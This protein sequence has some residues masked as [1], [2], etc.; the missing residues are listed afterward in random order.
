MGTTVTT[1]GRPVVGES[2]SLTWLSNWIRVTSKQQRTS[3][4]ARRRVGSLRV[5]LP[6]RQDRG[7]QRRPAN[8][9]GAPRPRLEELPA[10]GQRVVASGGELFGDERGP[11]ASIL[12]ARARLAQGQTSR[13]S[14]CCS[15]R[16]PRP[17]STSE[18]R[19]TAYSVRVRERA[20]I[21]GR[22]DRLRAAAAAA[23]YPFLRAQFLS[24]A[25]RRGSRRVTRPRRWRPTARSRKSWTRQ[26]QRERRRCA[27]GS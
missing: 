3:R 22:R 1:A 7:A 6:D 27:S 24:D 26:A 15:V 17:T 18:P 8:R 5:E 19:A 2:K 21:S 13:R 10:R 14:T 9:P 12:L 25:A 11:R 23:L 4:W 20:A 16:L